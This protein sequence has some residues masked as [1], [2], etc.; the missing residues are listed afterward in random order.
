MSKTATAASKLIRARF[1]AGYLPRSP[2]VFRTGVCNAREAHEAIRST[3]LARTLEEV[4]GRLGEDEAAP[5]VFVCKRAI[6]GQ[7]AT[8][9]LDRVRVELAFGGGDTVLAAAG[10]Q[11]L[12]DGFLRVC[13]E[14]H[15]EAGADHGPERRVTRPPPRSTNRSTVRCATPSV[16]VRFVILPQTGL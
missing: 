8:A 9:R 7:T 3:E 5:Y 6:A 10:A 4:D 14:G 1:G 15:D 16:T 13:R 2:R 11:T 12:F